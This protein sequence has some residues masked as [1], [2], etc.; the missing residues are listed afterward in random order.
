MIYHEQLAT[1]PLDGIAF[2]RLLRTLLCVKPG[3]S[4]HIHIG[5][6]LYRCTRS[7]GAVLTVWFVWV[8]ALV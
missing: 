4:E 2:D 7:R 6:S 1:V 5:N 8:K 3:H